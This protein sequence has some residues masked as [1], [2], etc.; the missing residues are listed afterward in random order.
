MLVTIC[1]PNER[2]A[3]W[4]RRPGFVS[5][6][7]TSLT[8]MS[9]DH[10]R[11]RVDVRVELVAVAVRENITA[12]RLDSVFCHDGL[13]NG[14]DVGVRIGRTEHVTDVIFG[15]RGGTAGEALV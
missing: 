13:R 7:A 14:A 4:M 11:D 6:R 10:T 5:N 8:G 2:A 12:G 15:A 9:I 1:E 3:V